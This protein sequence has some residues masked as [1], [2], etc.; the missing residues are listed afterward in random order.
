MAEEFN[1]N[2]EE[3]TNWNIITFNH[4]LKALEHFANERIKLNKK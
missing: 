1:T 3:V 2:W 4:K